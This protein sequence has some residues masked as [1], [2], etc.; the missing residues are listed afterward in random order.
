M[1][2]VFLPAMRMLVSRRLRSEGLS[3]GRIS[4]VLGITQASVSHYLSTSDARAY[5]SL[6]KLSFAR[7]DAEA[8]SSLLAEA[9]KGSPEL[10]V[11]TLV[12]AWS[13]MLGRGLICDAH[14]K[15][16]PSLA[17]CDVCLTTFAPREG[18]GSSAIEEV[19]QAVKV[20]EAAPSF[21]A[22]MPEVSV[23]LA[24]LW[25]DFDSLYNVV[26]IPG[27]IVR[28]KNS[29]R[30][31]LPPAFGASSHLATMLLAAR[32]AVPEHRAVINLRFD[33]KMAKVLRR[34]RVRTLLIEAPYPK[35]AEDPTL[36]AFNRSLQGFTGKFG[37]VVAPGGAGMEPIL[38]LFG[39]TP[40]E[41]AREAVRISKLYSAR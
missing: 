29:A 11:T 28:V 9:A 1:V 6:A 16:Y 25:G 18:E 30:A 32:S 23:N 24:Y 41:V 33:T 4:S 20:I 7:E 37:A 8:L 36:D 5:D 19:S 21:P 2:D 3:Q 17:K 15:A 34:T 22:V 13:S 39:R 26:A 40:L 35:V 14:R 27:R 38:Y 12:N 10:G 31:L